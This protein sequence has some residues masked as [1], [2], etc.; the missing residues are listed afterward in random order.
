MFSNL[1]INSSKDQNGSVLL[2]QPSGTQTAGLKRQEFMKEMRNMQR[3][4][5]LNQKRS[6]PKLFSM[7][8]TSQNTTNNNN[9]TSTEDSPSNVNMDHLNNHPFKDQLLVKILEFYQETVT[10][11]KQKIIDIKLSLHSSDT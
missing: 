4:K 1:N 10:F 6:Q 3:Q 7:P 8:N 5:I 11:T 2:D 9:T